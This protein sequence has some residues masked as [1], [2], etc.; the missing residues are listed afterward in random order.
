MRTFPLSGLC[1]CSCAG[2][3]KEWRAEA[4]CVCVC[5]CVCLCVKEAHAEAMRGA[6]SLLHVSGHQCEK[7]NWQGEPVRKSSTQR[8]WMFACVSVRVCQDGAI[9]PLGRRQLY[10]SFL[11]EKQ[12]KEILTERSVNYNLCCNS[13]TPQP[14]PLE[15]RKRYENKRE[16]LCYITKLRSTVSWEFRDVKMK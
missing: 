8:W 5:M 12:K 11:L 7:Q 16:N 1:F 6:L 13:C 9:S 3:L 4:M 15:K 2:W 10:K 14:A